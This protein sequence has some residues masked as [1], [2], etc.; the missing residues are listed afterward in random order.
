MPVI[1]VDKVA[2]PKRIIGIKW[3]AEEEERH[4][5]SL[6]HTPPKRIHLTLQGDQL[7]EFSPM[8]RLFTLG[9]F[10]YSI[11]FCQKM[12]QATFWAIFSQTHLVN[13]F[14]GWVPT[15]GVR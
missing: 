2:D 12:D 4:K 9:S 14:R 5:G 10:L 6:T 11:H 1:P 3:R 8:G 7:G 15:A 13:L